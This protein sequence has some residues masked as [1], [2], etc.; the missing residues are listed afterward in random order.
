VTAMFL[1][2]RRYGLATP[3]TDMEWRYIRAVIGAFKD[4]K[5]KIDG[6][7]VAEQAALVRPYE[8]DMR[9]FF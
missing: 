4:R 9:Q 1:Q 5:K 7:A 3:L 8:D 6:A 2:G